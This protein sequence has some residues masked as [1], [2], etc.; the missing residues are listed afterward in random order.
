MV[1]V[2]VVVRFRGARVVESVVVVVAVTSGV[3]VRGCVGTATSHV[4]DGGTVMADELAALTA[5][6]RSDRSAGGWTR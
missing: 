4:G 2:V 3:V 1:V 6:L 5:V